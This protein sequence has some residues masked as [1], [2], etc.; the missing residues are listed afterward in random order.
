MKAYIDMEKV[1]KFGDIEIKKQMFCQHKKP[2]SIKNI[3]INKILIKNWY[4]I[5]SLLVKKDLN[6][7]L[8]TKMLQKLDLYLYFSQKWVHIE[9]TLMKLKL[10]L[11]W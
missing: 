1:I 2:I 3:G 6:I 9:K 5:G 7:S 10:C 4:L 8:T 11:F